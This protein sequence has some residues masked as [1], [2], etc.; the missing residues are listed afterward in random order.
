MESGVRCIALLQKNA[1]KNPAPHITNENGAVG[2]E[3]YEGQAMTRRSIILLLILIPALTIAQAQNWNFVARLNPLLDDIVPVDAKV[4]KLVDNF[5]FLEGPV[6]V[7]KGG[8]LL[9][10]D[11]PANVIFKFSP[12]DGKAAVAVPYS[13]FT[14]A[15]SSGAG[16]QLNN[17]HG[18]V[19]LLGSNAVTLDPQGR[20]VYCAH[21]DHQV[22]RLEADGRRTVL[23]SQFEGKRLNS[24]N[25]LVYK[26]DGSLYFTDPPAGLR[27]GDKDS[28]KELP[29]NGVY[30]LRGGKLQLLTKDMTL[31]NGLAFTP[32]EKYLYVNDSVK[33]TIMRYEVQPDDTIANG[34]LF[35]DM[36]SDKAPGGPDGMK[37]DQRGNVYCTGPGGFWIMSP[38]GKHLGTVLTSELPA[39][40]AF[41]DSDG[42][43]LYL[44]ARTGLYRIRLKIPG[45]PPPGNS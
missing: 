4:E 39:N 6:W 19:T 23:A 31:P 12:E 30:L 32:D 44:T 9:F 42:K 16:M 38:D 27:D 15:D 1:R 37:V 7:R 33:K 28:K 5:G 26:S 21:G 11:I 13:G 29:F 25:D 17:G 22:V 43:S 40:L 45:I 35:I 34:Q 18:T 2:C 36:T 3:R 8:F 41:G 14:G 24:P 10:S 20:I